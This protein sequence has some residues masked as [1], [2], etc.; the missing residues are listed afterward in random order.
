[1]QEVDISRHYNSHS[2]LIEWCVTTFG[3]QTPIWGQV[4]TR[5]TKWSYFRSLERIT[6]RFYY[7]KDATLFKLIWL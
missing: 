2:D 5:A 1:M 4:P 6:F 7:I 3:S